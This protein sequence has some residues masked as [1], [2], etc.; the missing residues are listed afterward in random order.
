[1]IESQNFTNN[2]KDYLAGLERMTIVLH[3]NNLTINVRNLDL[4]I[5]VDIVKKFQIKVTLDTK[6][7]N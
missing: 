2:L 5:I 3:L 6:V 7:V 1:M 4:I